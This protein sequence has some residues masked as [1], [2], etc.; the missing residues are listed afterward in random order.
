[1]EEVL[2]HVLSNF[3][4]CSHVT[5]SVAV[6]WC[7]EHRHNI[8]I[9]HDTINTRQCKSFK[10]LQGNVPVRCF[11]AGG[12]INRMVFT[13][14][15]STVGGLVVAGDGGWFYKMQWPVHTYVCQ[16]IHRRLSKSYLCNLYVA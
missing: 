2:I 4:D 9:L 16:I 15:K 10:I 3:E 11:H 5:A 1:M 13:S 6:I 14:K 12:R 7:A 8:L